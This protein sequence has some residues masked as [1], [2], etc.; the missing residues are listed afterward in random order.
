M[1]SGLPPDGNIQKRIQQIHL[2]LA[3]KYEIVTSNTDSSIFPKNE[4]QISLA[5]LEFLLD[6]T[7]FRTDIEQPGG[8]KSNMTIYFE[9][10]MHK[11][12]WLPL[13]NKT[14]LFDSYP[15]NHE[16][17][18]I[19]FYKSNISVHW[20]WHSKDNLL[21]KFLH[22]IDYFYNMGKVKFAYIVT[23]SESLLE[24]QKSS[25]PT[26]YAS[27][28]TH[29]GFLT[30]LLNYRRSGLCPIVGLGIKDSAIV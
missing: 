28:T 4:M 1:D 2:L 30:Q 22:D 10:Q 6:L 25:D 20:A 18:I 21:Y 8:P 5:F 29:L 27:T 26:R 14:N 24:A 7:F 9:A 16:P 11:R 17:I 3:N 19:P 23:R 13:N 15:Q 12:A